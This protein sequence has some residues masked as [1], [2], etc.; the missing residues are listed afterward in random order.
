MAYAQ[1]VKYFNSFW[2]KKVV[3]QAPN[4]ANPATVKAQVQA[5]DD[6][7]IPTPNK[8]Y[9]LEPLPTWPGLPWNPV[10]YPEFPWNGATISGNNDFLGEQRQW[11]IEES[12]I[13]GGYNNT[14]VSLGERAY[15]STV[16]DLQEHRKSSMIYSGIYNSRTGVNNTN[17]F[18]IA[19]D[20]TKSLNPA[21]GSIQKL[22]P[23]N[24]NLNI[25]QEDKIQKALI[26]KDAVYS[27]EG[28]PMQTQSNVV[29]GQIIPYL[30]EYGISTNPESFAT[31]GFQKYFADQARGIIGRL[32]RD[33]ITEISEY[34]MK[35]FFRD[36]LKSINQTPAPVT[37][38]V[39]LL[40]PPPGSSMA[41]WQNGT[42][43][44]Q[45]DLGDCSCCVIEPGSI[46]LMQNNSGSWEST[47][48]YVIGTRGET[49]QITL[50]KAIG[51][52]VDGFGDLTNW[53]EFIKIQYSVKDKILGGWD[54]HNR[55]YTVSLQPTNPEDSC[56]PGRQYATLNFDENINGWVSF[57][58]YKPQ[59]MC[60][61]KNT[62]YSSPN[63]E[64]F[65]HYYN[66][67]TKNN[68]GYFYNQD[69]A[70]AQITFIFNPSIS[71][72]KSFQ[73][74]SYEGNSGWEVTTYIS[75]E[76][77]FVQSPLPVTYVDPLA[78]AT[79][80]KAFSDKTTSIA[81]YEEGRYEY[82]G[83]KYRSGFD[84]KENRY[85][86]NLVN[87]SEAT[88]GEVVYWDGDS[89]TAAPTT[90]IKGYYVTVSMQ[91]DKN[92]DL[93]GMKELFAVSSNY[94]MSSI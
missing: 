54:I 2:M 41:T 83:V 7:A 46:I 90:G 55:C 29:I 13:R 49:C 3:A 11:Y 50:Q 74:I 65:S 53:P 9:S 86:A 76:T 73:T 33:G 91:T 84:R 52:I 14:S 35:D 78:Y 38:T 30:G 4:D 39:P 77:G 88:E 69:H 72:V 79:S 70:P 71:M 59:M 15:T 40:W 60:S 1:R 42:Q 32:S 85:V 31:F 36:S 87:A 89:N 67:P 47:G 6:G 63:Y 68:R 56:N 58:D 62:F 19:E 75:D 27:A 43:L 66:D 81:S 28:S 48:S 51:N 21:Y 80:W 57:Y 94:V 37:L 20:I 64:L 61:L 16:F 34:G 93:G 92:T 23:E 12:R 10:G 26:D 44:I 8:R 24:T 18:S 5:G 17:V 82:Q 22:Y 25:F 45:V